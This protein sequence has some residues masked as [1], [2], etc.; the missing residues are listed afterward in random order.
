M[1]KKKK[2]TKKPKDDEEDGAKS[3]AVSDP[4]DKGPNDIYPYAEIL[5]RV[6]DAISEKNP[7]LMGGK[8]FT[9]I[10]PQV[11]REGSKKTVFVNFKEMAKKMHRTMEHVMSY[12]N[13]ELG[14]PCSLD[15]EGK[16]T[17]KGRFTPKQIESVVR[18][19]MLAYVQCQ[20]CKNYDS[21]LVKD[22][23]TRLTFLECNRCGARMSVQNVEKGFHATNRADRKAAKNA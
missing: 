10:P 4:K 16:L 9:M 12:F 2:K 5:Q 1:D 23:M 6:Y 11:A 17:F 21:Q 18:K 13:A 14:V 3:G 8:K 15:P 19:Y 7:E 22:S 20:M